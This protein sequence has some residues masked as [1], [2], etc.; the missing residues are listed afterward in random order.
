MLRMMVLALA[1]V[2]VSAAFAQE[3]SKPA[4]PAKP[5]HRKPEAKAG[6]T[7]GAKEHKQAEARSGE[8]KSPLDFEMKDIDGKDV[9]LSDYKGKVVLIVNVASKC[10]FTPQYE[11]LEALHKKYAGRG[12]VI[13]GFPA[14]NFR[15]Q[16][17]GTNAEIKEFCTSKYNVG[18]KMFSKVSVKGDDICPLYQWLTS[19]EKDG[20]HGGD[21][22]WNFTKFLVDRDGKVIARYEPKV[23]P[24]DKQ[25][26]DSIE[27]ALGKKE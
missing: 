15:G 2:G 7:D 14:N 18:F 16:E 17:P 12:L 4:E 5:E 27:T 11:Q 22:Q 25:V 1:V 20:D 21:I 13:L 8:A 23:K 3:K 19:K 26:V 10:G 6:S 24:D 9:K